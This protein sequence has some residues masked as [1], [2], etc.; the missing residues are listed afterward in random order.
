MNRTPGGG[1]SELGRLLAEVR[2]AGGCSHPIRL[3]GPVTAVG[4]RRSLRTV[5]V[6]C[7]DR[8]DAVCPACARRYR[9]DA[10]QLVAAGLRGGKGV[11][12]AVSRHPRCFVT[13]TAP[14]FGAVHRPTRPPARCRPRRRHPR[15]PHGLPLWC[16][17]RHRVD[18]PAV[19]RPLCRWCFDYPGAVL[20]NA[21]V[22]AL[23]PRTAQAVRRQLAVAA[24]L[25]V[26]SVGSVLRLSY[27]K[28]AEL[29]RRGLVHLHVVARVDGPG[30]PATPPPAWATADALEAAVRRAVPAVSVAGADGVRRGWGA[31]LDVR[32]LEAAGDP[33]AVAAYVAK[34]ATKA[35]ADA[36]GLARRLR[37][38]AEV[39]LLRRHGLDPHLA[40]LVA[41][42][43]ALGA[44][45]DL[46]PLRLRAHAHTLGY[47]GHVLTKSLAYSTTFG[48][49]RRE[50]ARHQAA[51]SGDEPDADGA[52]RYVGRG[53]RDPAAADLAHVLA[54]LP[55]SRPFRG[56]SPDGSRSVPHPADLGR[57]AREV[58]GSGTGPG[59][60][61]GSARGAMAP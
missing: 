30:G 56:S 39:L 40:R 13:L 22:S 61:A 37:S 46:A 51:D 12:G 16:D 21:G 15:C 57:F 10:W 42:A 11:P 32:P 18:D 50:R 43:W 3:A 41:T 14:T 17:G 48:A 2:A 38:D 31:Q 58:P 53:Y 25:P 24:G 44:D 5:T 49:L 6:A 60:A 26:R 29:Q 28:V 23:W 34:Y 33:G 52:W 47:R 7:K 19:G 59:T 55:G 54:T 1:G 4:G 8:R 20:W 36:D 35:T 27:T 9:G 45:A